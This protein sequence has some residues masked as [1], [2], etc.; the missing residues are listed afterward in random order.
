MRIQ[1]NR[2]TYRISQTLWQAEHAN[3]SFVLKRRFRSGR[4]TLRFRGHLESG[5][6][7]ASMK[8]YYA[9]ATGRFDESSPVVLGRLPRAGEP[10]EVQISFDLPR[11][12]RAIRFDPASSGCRFHLSNLTLRRKPAILRAWGAVKSV[13]RYFLRSPGG[14]IADVEKYLGKRSLAA[15]AGTATL[16]TI[17][18]PADLPQ[19]VPLNLDVHIGAPPRLNVLIPGLTLPTLSGGPNTAINLTYR[20]AQAG[21][22]VRYISSD[23]AMDHDTDRLWSH[24]QTLTG[25]SQ[26]LP[27]V[28]LATAH[29][30]GQPLPIGADDVFLATAWWTAQ[31]VKR[32]LPRLANQRFLYLIQDYEPAL[33][34]WS[35]SSALAQETYRMDFRGVIC[36]HFLAEYLA[37]QRVG[38]FADP[39]FLEQ[40]CVTFEPAVD[41]SKFYPEQNDAPLRKK[42]LLFY[43]RPN[44]PRNLYELG[45]VALK[46]AA[47]RGA[48]PPGAW[49]LWFMGDNLPAA[50]LGNGITIRQYPWSS[51]DDY[52]RLLRGADVGLS[53]MLS[54]HT[55]YPPLEMAAC[56]ATVVTNTFSVKTSEKLRAISGNLFPVEPELDAIVAGLMQAALRADDLRTRQAQAQLHV[57][58]RWND[59]FDPLIPQMLELCRD[60]AA[61]H[62]GGRR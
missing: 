46:R 51:Y 3:P 37:A 60:C 61:S 59:V 9:D 7:P 16:P 47:D 31:L 4:Y 24:I 50:D 39:G 38:R 11:P 58:T 18:V 53:L 27:N 48:F 44:A 30:R 54:P 52:A 40:R 25:I 29:D 12:T 14:L 1:Q 8:L 55:S 32:A 36:G 13:A 10:E 43:A 5:S 21:V 42:R 17:V 23:I 45:L 33:Y 26:R 35:T 57:P 28:E 62:P 41:S 34:A 22:P 15:G 56:G 20:L 19:F 6:N 49:E 2:G